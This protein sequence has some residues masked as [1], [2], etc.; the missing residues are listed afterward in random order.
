M[1]SY[2]RL[3]KLQKR[4]ELAQQFWE[5][6]EHFS[7]AAMALGVAF[8]TR[9]IGFYIVG[10][11]IAALGISTRLDEHY[12]GKMGEIAVCMK[13]LQGD[14][15]DLEAR[16]EAYRKRSAYFDTLKNSY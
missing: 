8:A 4:Y 13:H 16:L 14:T 10:A 1:T 3:V 12:Q 7:F 5:K 9:Q 15:L 11:G 6:A 2:E